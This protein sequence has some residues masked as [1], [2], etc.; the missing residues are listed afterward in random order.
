[1]RD[2]DDETLFT[3]NLI[4]HTGQHTTLGEIAAGRRLNIEIDVL[5]RYLQR[6]VE[7]RG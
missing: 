6:M 5:A 7:A 1:V 2:E 4:P 3:I